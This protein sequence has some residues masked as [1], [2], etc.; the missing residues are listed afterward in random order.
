MHARGGDVTLTSARLATKMAAMAA[1]APAEISPLKVRQE[2]DG[3][4]GSVDE[5]CVYL[6]EEDSASGEDGDEEMELGR[7]K[8]SCIIFHVCLIYVTPLPG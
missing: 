2:E 5:L 8:Y 6:G 3:E 7:L 1:A 4:S